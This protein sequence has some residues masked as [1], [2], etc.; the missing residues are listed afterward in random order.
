[1]A[2]RYPRK[3]CRE[4]EY[5]QLYNNFEHLFCS[6]FWG[7]EIGPGW[8]EYIADFLVKF[9]RYMKEKQYNPE[10]YKIMQVKNKFG[11]LRIYLAG[12]DFYINSL[13]AE[14]E[15]NANDCCIICG[16]KAL[17]SI[18]IYTQNVRGTYKRILVTKTLDNHSCSCYII[19]IIQKE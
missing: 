9:D 14:T 5:E 11:S 6:S 19:C 1:M 3:Y 4:E 2:A 18:G 7:F 12:S 10:D 16:K 17:G 15:A 13:I 8:F